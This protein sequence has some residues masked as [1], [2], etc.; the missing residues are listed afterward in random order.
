[1]GDTIK[2]AEAR[3]ELAELRA[4]RGGRTSKYA[5]YLSEVDAIKKGEV[6][7]DVV[8]G[9]NE[10][11]GLRNYLDRN[12]PEKY[13]VK[14]VKHPDDKGEDQNEARYKIYIFNQKDVE[15]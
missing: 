14:A 15:E 2:V 3:A 13:V 1:M 10:V 4:G 11:S 5:E 6:Y 8:N 12:R 7:T 9:Y